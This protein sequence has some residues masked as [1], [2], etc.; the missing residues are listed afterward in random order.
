MIVTYIR[1]QVL[2]PLKGAGRY[3]KLGLLGGLLAIPAGVLAAVGLLRALQKVEWLD[4]DR[5]A[6][7]WGVYLVSAVV[8]LAV[9]GIFIMIGL[10][11]DRRQS[12]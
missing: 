9:G 11:T 6:W 8:A 1:Q 12:P 7:S 10:R 3:V 4:I 2:G 5:G